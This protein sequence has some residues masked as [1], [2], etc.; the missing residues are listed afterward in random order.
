MTTPTA[1]ASQLEN[2]LFD[3]HSCV[4][5]KNFYSDFFTVMFGIRR[6]SVLAPFLFVVFLD[7]LAETHVI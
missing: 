3:C 5:W 6:G 4:K 2:M 1:Y 7:E